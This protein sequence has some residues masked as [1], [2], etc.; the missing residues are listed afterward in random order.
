MIVV[1]E[2]ALISCMISFRVFIIN[3][4]CKRRLMH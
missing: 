4:V 2:E 3:T 1:L